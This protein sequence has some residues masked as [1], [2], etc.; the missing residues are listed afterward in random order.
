M[1]VYKLILLAARVFL[2]FAADGEEEEVCE[3]KAALSGDRAACSAEVLRGPLDGRGIFGE[4]DGL[5]SSRSMSSFPSPLSFFSLQYNS[6]DSILS[7][8]RYP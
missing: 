7:Q 1:L 8:F 4:R 5:F 6:K 3:E 2:A